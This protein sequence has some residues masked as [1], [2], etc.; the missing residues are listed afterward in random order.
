MHI[1]ARSFSSMMRL[2]VYNVYADS[3]NRP[4]SAVVTSPILWKAI[5]QNVKLKEKSDV[6]IQVGF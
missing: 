5:C 2:S 6:D 4:D 1:H 3:V